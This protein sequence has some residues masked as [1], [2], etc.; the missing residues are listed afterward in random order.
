MLYDKADPTTALFISEGAASRAAQMVVK[1]F[2]ERLRDAVAA[3]HFNR[4]ELL[5]YH[6]RLYFNDFRPPAYLTNSDFERLTEER[7]A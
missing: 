4:G 2:P 1:A 3:A 6:V 5:G 7:T